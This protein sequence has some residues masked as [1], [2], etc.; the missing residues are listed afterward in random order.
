MKDLIKFWTN[1]QVARNLFISVQG[2]LRLEAAD[3]HKKDASTP[4][5]T[6]SDLQKV[7]ET[8]FNSHV[9][10]MQSGVSN[11]D[12][13]V[14]ATA[15][16]DWRNEVMGTTDSDFKAR[17]T[18]V[19]DDVNDD[20]FWD[21]KAM[22]VELLKPI[23]TFIDFLQ[24]DAPRLS[25]VYSRHKELAGHIETTLSSPA[26]T[27]IKTKNKK[28]LSQK[29]WSTQEK[30]LS[31][32]VKRLFEERWNYLYSTVIM[33]AFFL[34]PT[35]HAP[36]AQAYPPGSVSTLLDFFKSLL[37]ESSH[38]ALT[39]EFTKW[40][41]FEAPFNEDYLWHKDSLTDVVLW[42]QQFSESCPNLSLIAIVLLS[43]PAT[44]G[45]V[46]RSFSNLDFVHSKLRNKLGPEKRE[47]LLKIYFNLRSLWRDEVQV[48]GDEQFHT[49]PAGNHV[50]SLPKVSP[51]DAGPVCVACQGTGKHT[52]G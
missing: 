25:K 30:K 39:R 10:S 31:D 24:S 51:P 52:T 43:L 46:E 22:I 27:N 5:V 19:K 18:G 15:H 23:C 9:D 8:R 1:V 47:K 37:P 7:V 11:R 6:C 32:E 44:S 45:A 21:Q 14:S 20:D 29:E 50:V 35:N 13:F 3:K 36:V 38:G 16:P 28:T 26:F 2:K 48:I 41:V 4:L 49:T 12:V 33:A 34:D 40:R 42:W 17:A